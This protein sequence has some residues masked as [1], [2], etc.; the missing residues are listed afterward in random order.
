MR[1]ESNIIGTGEESAI[2]VEE[3]NEIEDNTITM[4]NNTEDNSYCFE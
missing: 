2:L 4:K 3:S 1:G